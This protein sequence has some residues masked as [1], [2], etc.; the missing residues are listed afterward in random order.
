MGVREKPITNAY[1]VSEIENKPQEEFIRQQDR[2]QEF[3]DRALPHGQQKHFKEYQPPAEQ[4]GKYV[5]M[6]SREPVKCV[7][8]GDQ[9]KSA[10]GWGQNRHSGAADPKL[11]TRPIGAGQMDRRIP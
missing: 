4:P 9:K 3:L 8:D 7:M 1:S 10:L 11:Y 2:I 5:E 6:V